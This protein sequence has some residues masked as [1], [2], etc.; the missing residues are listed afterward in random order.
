MASPIREVG[1]SMLGRYTSD[2]GICAPVA[3]LLLSSISTTSDLEELSVV[4]ADGKYRICIVSVLDAPTHSVQN[5][6][7]D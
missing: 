5:V 1:K 7:T 6:I 4:E 2:I 3:L